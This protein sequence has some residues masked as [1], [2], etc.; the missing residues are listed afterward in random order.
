MYVKWHRVIDCGLKGR[1]SERLGKVLAYPW[2]WAW[3]RQKDRHIVE[4]GA[5]I[6]I[7]VWR[8]GS[9]S[10]TETQIIAMDQGRGQWILI[11]AYII[12]VM[13]LNN[14]KPDQYI[15]SFMGF[16]YHVLFTSYFLMIIA[17]QKHLPKMRY[18][19]LFSIEETLVIIAV[20]VSIIN[21]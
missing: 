7:L 3:I 18:Q 15:I 21:Q 17:V 4:F 8:S 20:L 2:E 5:R 6:G 11:K 14:W 12:N 10:R 9:H 16:L 19:T 1:W 13:E